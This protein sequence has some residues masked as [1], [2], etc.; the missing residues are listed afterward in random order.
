METLGICEGLLPSPCTA[1]LLWLISPCSKPC[2][3]GVQASGLEAG[4]LMLRSLLTPQLPA[5]FYRC[6][7]L[8]M[9][10]I[11]TYTSERQLSQPSK[12]VS[13]CWLLLTR[14]AQENLAEVLKERKEKLKPHAR[15]ES[16]HHQHRKTSAAEFKSAQSKAYIL[17]NPA[18]CRSHMDLCKHRMKPPSQQSHISSLTN[19]GNQDGITFTQNPSCSQAFPRALPPA[20]SLI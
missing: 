8:I 1:E 2:A 16:A 20:N 14:P 10:W 7:C 15:S 19:A 17:L 13:L 4:K 18:P 5:Q 12:S 11:R 9:A 3:L 6:K